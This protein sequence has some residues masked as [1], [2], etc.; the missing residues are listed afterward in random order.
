MV[1]HLQTAVAIALQ[2]NIVIL[3]FLQPAKIA[4]E[5]DFRKLVALRVRHVRRENTMINKDKLKCIRI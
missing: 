3:E 1:F 4:P 2:E 5:A